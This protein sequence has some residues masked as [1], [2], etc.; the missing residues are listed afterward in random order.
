MADGNATT[1]DTV[2]LLDAQTC[3]DLMD[4]YSEIGGDLTWLNDKLSVTG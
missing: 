4:N 3:A 2:S 1:H